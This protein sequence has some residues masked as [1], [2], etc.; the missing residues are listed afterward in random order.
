M[1]NPTSSGGQNWGNSWAGRKPDQ[2]LCNSLADEEN[3][4]KPVQLISGPQ[5]IIVIT[6]KMMV[7]SKFDNVSLPIWRGPEPSTIG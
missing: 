2:N 5:H 7:I 3:G 4:R 6:I 1:T